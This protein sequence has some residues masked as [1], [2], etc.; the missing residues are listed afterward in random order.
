MWAMP[1]TGSLRIQWSPHAAY[2]DKTSARPTMIDTKAM[3]IRMVQML[4]GSLRGSRGVVLSHRHS[5]DFMEASLPGAVNPRYSEG[6]GP[7]S[8]GRAGDPCNRRG[9]LA[10]PRTGPLRGA[11]AL[12]SARGRLGASW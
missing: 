1:W 6:Q 9:Y 11:E 2:T 3:A 4:T 12:R 7:S 8:G 5:R 10:L